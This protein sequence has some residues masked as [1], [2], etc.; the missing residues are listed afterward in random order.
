VVNKHV[1]AYVSTDKDKERQVVML[2]KLQD[3]PCTESF[4]IHVAITVLDLSDLNCTDY[5][6]E[7]YYIV[8]NFCSNEND[9]SNCDEFYSY[10]MISMN[11][12]HAL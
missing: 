4:G 5:E 3:G 1:S 2:Y 8:D 7:S 10:P 11:T 9:G 12:V 6:L